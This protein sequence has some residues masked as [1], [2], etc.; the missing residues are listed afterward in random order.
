MYVQTPPHCENG[1]DDKAC[2]VVGTSHACY[3]DICV[4][5]YIYIYIYT[6]IY[7][8][9]YIYVYIYIYIYIYGHLPT[10]PVK[11]FIVCVCM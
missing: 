10:L 3:S 5:I 7:I 1:W 2:L 11:L 9:I 4:Y 8:Y 6:Y